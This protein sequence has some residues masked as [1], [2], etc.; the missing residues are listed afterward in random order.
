MQLLPGGDYA[1]KQDQGMKL[2]G[3]HLQSVYPKFGLAAQAGVNGMGLAPQRE[4]SFGK[5]AFLPETHLT[6]SSPLV[7]PRNKLKLFRQW[8]KYWNMS[9][10][11]LLEKS[12]PN[13][14]WMRFLQ[15]WY[16]VSV[17]KCAL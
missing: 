2:E 14:Q 7:T 1:V 3:I 5:F 11:V 4:D 13:M 6:E 10:P 16:I 17:W 8:A 15:V 9:L 12:P